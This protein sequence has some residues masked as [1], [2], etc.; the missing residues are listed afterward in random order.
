MCWEEVSIILI[1]VNCFIVIKD[2]L[3]MLLDV[4]V[5]LRYALRKRYACGPFPQEA[6]V[7]KVQNIRTFSHTPLKSSANFFSKY[8]GPERAKNIE[9][10]QKSVGS[11]EKLP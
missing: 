3:F 9:A 10:G 11:I 8:R 4:V 1:S 7:K 6:L 2:L 5:S